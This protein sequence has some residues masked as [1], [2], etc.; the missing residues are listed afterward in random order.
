MR[1]IGSQLITRGD[2]LPERDPPVRSCE[3]LGVI[4]GLIRDQSGLV[5]VAPPSLWQA[6]VAFAIRRSEV[7]YRMVLSMNRLSRRWFA[8]MGSGVRHGK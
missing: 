6:M 3:V 2:A 5:A 7:V 4:V 8:M 1:A